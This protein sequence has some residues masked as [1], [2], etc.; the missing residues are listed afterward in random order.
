MSFESS[1]KIDDNLRAELKRK[2]DPDARFEFYIETT[3]APRINLSEIPDVK[4]IYQSARQKTIVIVEGSRR[5]VEALTNHEAVVRLRGS[6]R[7][8]SFS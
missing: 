2:T 6:H 1:P 3:P 4:S 8:A 5:S 7:Y